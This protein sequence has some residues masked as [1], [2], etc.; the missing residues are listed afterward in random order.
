MKS[1]FNEKEIVEG[2]VRGQADCQRMFFQY[3]YPKMLVLCRRYASNDDEAKDLL[4][5][6]FIKVFDNL[7]KFRGESS[8]KTWVSRV[9]VN[10]AL[11]HIKKN[12][13]IQFVSIDPGLDFD[14]MDDA[15]CLEDLEVIH[16]E[17]LLE[18][19]QELP[20]GYRTILNLYAVE[21]F[22][23]KQI[24]E[25]LGIAEGTSKSQLAKARVF[26]K[27]SLEKIK[28]QVDARA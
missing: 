27:K 23:H 10:N 1:T 17:M 21:G 3:F 9:M 20:V 5:E 26:L 8:L 15:E 18:L 28:V 11:N 14:V 24:A 12:S 4:K 13:K 6:G 7:S 19:I 25:S 2:C 16:P 22:T